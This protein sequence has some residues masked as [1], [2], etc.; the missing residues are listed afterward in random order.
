[1]RS[2]VVVFPASMCAMMPI[3]RV[4]SM[5]TDLA[6]KMPSDS[7]RERTGSHPFQR[8]SFL[9]AGDWARQALLQ[10]PPR[11]R[12]HVAS[13]PAAWALAFLESGARC[14]PAVAGAALPVT[15]GQRRNI[16][17]QR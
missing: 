16:S 3:F 15:D 12:R 5:G 9:S 7:L 6:N 13:V 2:V 1:M 10:R 4:S 14:A 8:A 11:A 17:Y